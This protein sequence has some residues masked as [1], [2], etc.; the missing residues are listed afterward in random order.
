MRRIPHEE[1]IV[2]CV[3]EGRSHLCA[4]RPGI[5]T[6]NDE[7]KLVWLT[8]KDEALQNISDCILVKVLSK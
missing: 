1:C 4:H 2:F 8:G 3:R 7:W 5:H 6:V